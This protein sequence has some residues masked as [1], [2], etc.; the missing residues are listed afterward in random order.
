M[1][2]LFTYGISRSSPDELVVW[3][4]LSLDELLSEGN[5]DVTSIKFGSVVSHRW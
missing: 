1:R 5:A 2:A 4:L 3:L